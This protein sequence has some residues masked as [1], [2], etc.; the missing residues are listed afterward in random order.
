MS[1]NSQ[2]KVLRNAPYRLSV[3]DALRLLELKARPIRTKKFMSDDKALF[4]LMADE[5][6]EIMKGF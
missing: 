4:A 3:I 6:N 2:M 1:P 5:C